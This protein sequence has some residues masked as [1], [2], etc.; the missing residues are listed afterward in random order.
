MRGRLLIS[1]NNTPL[2]LAV[3]SRSMLHINRHSLTT[4]YLTEATISIM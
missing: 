4:Y 2:S 3:V 1:V